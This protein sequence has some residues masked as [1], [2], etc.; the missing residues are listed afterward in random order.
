MVRNADDSGRG[1]FVR[2]EVGSVGATYYVVFFDAANFP[3]PF[4]I[5]NFSEVPVTYYQSGV[6]DISQLRSVLKPHYSVPY[7]LDEPS[8]D[9]QLSLAAPGGAIEIYNMNV[10]GAGVELTY[11]NFIYIVMSSTIDLAEKYDDDTLECYGRLPVSQQPLVLDVEGTRVILARKEAGKRSQ[12]WRMTSTGMLVHEGS[13]PPQDPI[14]AS[15]SANRDG[16][17]NLPP[18][19]NTNVLVL[20]IAGA[21]V[22]PQSCTPL[23]LRKPDERR[24]LT[25]R[26]KF[27]HDGRLICSH[28]GLYVQAKDGFMGLVAGKPSYSIILRSDPFCFN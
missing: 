26:W 17:N 2:V 15:Q 18:P 19:P 13:S 24:Q 12:L 11:E 8:L 10:I 3:P 20:D 4:R 7:A 1:T 28:R 14:N 6:Q 27:T 5:D 9:Q 23:M 25:Q 22:Q 16:L 21:A